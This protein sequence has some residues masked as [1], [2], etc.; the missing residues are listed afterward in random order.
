M[1]KKGLWKLWLAVSGINVFQRFWNQ[2]RRQTPK[3]LP[4][5]TCPYRVITY[6]YQSICRYKTSQHSWQRIWKLNFQSILCSLFKF[7]AYFRHLFFII[8]FAR[9]LHPPRSRLFQYSPVSIYFGYKALY[10]CT[11]LTLSYIHFRN[12]TLFCIY[13]TIRWIWRNNRWAVLTL[14]GTKLLIF[15]LSNTI[16]KCK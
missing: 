9:K 10:L 13:V 7:S 15:R 5:L 11:A 6:W 4:L 16:K 12:A 8:S 2:F 1:G 3:F 14:S